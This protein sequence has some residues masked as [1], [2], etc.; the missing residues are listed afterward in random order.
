M[1][2]VDRNTGSLVWKFKAGDII[3]GSVTVK[4][5][6]AFFGSQDGFVYALN[7]ETGKLSWKYQTG[8][9]VNA[10]SGQFYK[11][12]FYIGSSNG[13]MHCFSEKGD[14]LWK[15][16]AGNAIFMSPAFVNDRLY[17]G[18]YD[19][20][21]YCLNTK[22]ELVWKFYVGEWVD[23]SPTVFSDGR[24]IWS[25]FG[26][27]KAYGGPA[28]VCFGAY[29]RNFYVLD[30][31]TGGL[32][33]M[34]RMDGIISW[35]NPAVK[36]GKIYFGDWSGQ[37]YCLDA[38]SGAI[39]WKILTGGN[40]DTQPLIHEGYIYFGSYD[41]NLYAFSLEGK[42]SWKYQTGGVVI[43]RPVIENGVIYFGSMDTYMYAI[44]L[45]T[46][47]VLWKFITGA[48]KPAPIESMLK[49]I[50]QIKESQKIFSGW[51]PELIKPAY[52][53]D[54]NLTFVAA[55]SEHAYASQTPYKTDSPYQLQQKKKKQ[56][57]E[58]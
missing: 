8:G 48:G 32:Q 38:G 39:D 31:E 54:R 43:S 57:W 21:F 33:W 26:E 55:P 52:K 14:L 49:M 19:K 51:K 58:R 25:A 29:T 9:M 24:E 47:K 44:D 45:E 27:K 50:D 36:D 46:R 5:N 17:F 56:P 16:K 3:A 11:G 13:F 35:S 1:Y 53:D 37:L 18:S 4:D 22:G 6:I 2:G 30:C 34:R 15:Y 7:A 20:H 23:N 10:I 12:N 41:G 28:S 40:I 42:L